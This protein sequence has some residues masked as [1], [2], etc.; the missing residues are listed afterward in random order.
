MHE[1]L[2]FLTP[3]YGTTK[4]KAILDTFTNHFEENK[5]DIKKIF[6]VKTDG[7][8]AVIG[9]HCEFVT[10]V[11][12]KIGH[13]FDILTLFINRLTANEWLTYCVHLH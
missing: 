9:R 7:A 12:K 11:E 8:P 10:L 4:G 6:S 2:C 3:I 1:Y 13:P 5:I